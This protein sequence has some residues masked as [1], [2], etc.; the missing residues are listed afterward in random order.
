VLFLAAMLVG[1]AW[2]SPDNSAAETSRTGPNSTASWNDDIHVH[3]KL[4]RRSAA[5]PITFR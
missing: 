4:L 2:W 1:M 3:A 5:V